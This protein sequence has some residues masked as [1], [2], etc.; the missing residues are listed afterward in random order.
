MLPFSSLSKLSK[1]QK[2]CVLFYFISFSEVYISITLLD[3]QQIQVYLSLKLCNYLS[4]HFLQSSFH[5]ESHSL[6]MAL[7]LQVATDVLTCNEA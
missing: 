4:F 3:I 1:L 6:F 5:N 2:Y 7:G